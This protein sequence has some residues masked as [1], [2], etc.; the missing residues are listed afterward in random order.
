MVEELRKEAHKRRQ[1]A[2]E[3]ITRASEELHVAKAFE[4]FA[5][6]HEIASLLTKTRPGS[7]P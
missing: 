5:D 6:R 4:A 1:R 3:L 7:Q 2:A